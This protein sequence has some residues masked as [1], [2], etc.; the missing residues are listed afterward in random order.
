MSTNQKDHPQP[1]LWAD[2]LLTWR[3]DEAAIE[4]VVG[5]MHE[6]Y[7]HW[8]N[9]FGVKRAKALY[10]LNATGFLQPLP[11]GLS[12]KT[13]K[14]FKVK[15]QAP[16]MSIRMMPNYLKSSW[17]N[18][19]T[20]KISAIINIG[21]LALGMAVAMLIALW[22]YDECS[23]NRYH[24]NFNRIARVM[25][26]ETWNGE[27]STSGYNP[28]PLSGALRS[29]FPSD[30]TSAAISTWTEEHILGFDDNRFNQAGNFM[31]VDGPE[32]LTLE[33][34]RGIRTG[35][36]EINSILLSESTATRLF[37]DID[38]LD[39]LIK[40]DDQAV[41]KVTGVYKDL[42]YNSDFKDVGFI[43]PFDLYLSLRPWMVKEDW[44]NNH[45]Q[46]L[47]QLSPSADF[48]KVSEKIKKIKPRNPD[49]KVTSRTE[50]ILHPMS[51]WHLYDQFEQGVNTGGRIR[52]VWMFGIIGVFVLLLACINFMNLST[53]RSEKRAREVGIRKAIGSIRSQLVS[54]FLTESLL[55][56]G[57][58]FILSVG[59]VQ[60]VLP[61][62]NKVADKEMDILW[63]SPLSW[64]LCMGFL[65]FT[66]LIAGS[67][68]AL[69]LSSFQ[70]VKVLKGTFK[71][72]RFAVIPRK[73]LVVVQFTVSIALIIGTIIVYQQ[74]QFTKN[75][76]VGYKGERLIYLKL[77][78]ND[79]HT[80][81]NAIRNELLTTGAATG[82]A[83]SYGF[84]IHNTANFGGFEWKGKDPNFLDNFAIE[85]VSHE[86][87]KTVGWEFISGRDF[88]KALASDSLAYVINESAAR[89][90]KLQNP[91]GEFLRKDD[92][93]YTIIGVIKDVISESPYKPVR[94][95]LTSILQWPAN[96]IS[97]RLNPSLQV[98]E[99]LAKVEQVFKKY[100]SNMPF[101]Y[102]FVD[103]AYA[104]KF[105]AEERIGNLSGFFA[106]LAVLI[107]C[108]GLFGLAVFMAEQRTKE[109]G[110]RKVLGAS[111]TNLW[112]MLSKEFLALVIISCVIAIPISYYVLHNWLQNYE[113][114]TEISWWIFVATIVG[115][116]IITLLTVSF[117]AIKA[118]LANPVKSLR[119]E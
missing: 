98:N 8:V 17:R 62:F 20:N 94:P 84:L 7:I 107:S 11:Y 90:M 81:Y 113:Y 38:P 45:V 76:A 12:R 89:Y 15:Q 97:I 95:T 44:E 118:A 112:Q 75:R 109:I 37:G 23:F 73:V 54:Q 63:G 19:L 105:D 83:E 18:L 42:P 28:L 3:L 31:E 48:S 66:G 52:F 71:A 35:L 114:R 43:A 41:V 70:P 14:N 88:S 26:Q 16:F 74:V 5:D 111:V 67:Y 104:R 106:V 6:L 2:R 55:V 40:L 101:D 68:P 36:K 110:I 57:L 33:M 21:G 93:T 56:T 91:I 61:W 29:S 85:W 39:K 24:K 99:G 64:G 25:R 58:S 86:Y 10:W 60:L 103:E 69:Y 4:E 51:K 96:T 59:M 50:F 100:A 30:I 1:P 32:I 117:Q 27:T 116:I 34:T 115:A 79:V 53:A 108:L 9:R 78:T 13:K 47:A 82:V 46:V 102:E 65:V 72:G 92:K 22:I 87:G 80:H 119:S 77:K 49:K